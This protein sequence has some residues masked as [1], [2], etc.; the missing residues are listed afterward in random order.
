[1]LFQ[2]NL[3][4]SRLVQ[5]GIAPPP[6]DEYT[7]AEVAGHLV[8]AADLDDESKKF[9]LETGKIYET[10]WITTGSRG[11]EASGRFLAG[12]DLP[13]PHKPK[14]KLKMMNFSGLSGLYSKLGDII[15]RTGSHPGL[16]AI[17][18]GF[19]SLNPSSDV[20]KEQPQAKRRRVEA[21]S[22]E[23]TVWQER[24]AGP[25]GS[26]L[27]VLDTAWDASSA[28]LA[29]AVKG[30]LMEGDKDGKTQ[31]SVLLYNVEKEA[32]I[33]VLRAPSQKQIFCLSFSSSPGVLAV[34]CKGGVVLWDLEST[35]LAVAKGAVISAA[36]AKSQL[37]PE[38][39]A[40]VFAAYRSLATNVDVISKMPP[41]YLMP[42]NGSVTTLCFSNISGRYLAYGGKESATFSVADL[43]LPLEEAATRKV[44]MV[45][46]DSYGGARSVSFSPDDKLLVFTT[47]HR[48]MMVAYETSSW[49][50]T[51]C[52]LPS[53]VCHP[54]WHP[55]GQLFF[56]LQN[57]SDVLCMRFY[58][59]EG[60]LKPTLSLCEHFE[61]YKG[62]NGLWVGECGESQKYGI[63]STL[64]VDPSG[65]RL[66]V[67]LR[68]GLVAIYHLSTPNSRSSQLQMKPVGLSRLHTATPLSYP[69]LS[70]ARNASTGAVLSAMWSDGL[71]SFLPLRFSREN[72]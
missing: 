11:L 58:S 4:E 20:D 15:S 2:Q 24:Y 22:E 53:P 37:S 68:D 18:Y 34:G 61:P 62:S 30:L 28:L 17:V 70:F 43:S 7:I 36:S 59:D 35:C 65:E 8:H 1:M 44:Q 9:V 12:S 26:D 13:A 32:F 56:H 66:A 69:L 29:I 33:G 50:A 52:Y 3:S 46:T 64:A 51:E 27:S 48:P 16:G 6:E 31:G 45:W 60:K 71:L 63:V 47:G 19:L 57:G 55:S 10:K 23:P 25:T 21:S 72:S 38:E 54:R 42:Y 67:A 39:K 5:E 40:G 41:W 49:K 14:G